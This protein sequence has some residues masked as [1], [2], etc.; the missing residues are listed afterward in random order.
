MK[1]KQV[2]PAYLSMPQRTADATWN[3]TL[4]DGNGNIKTGSGSFSGPYSFRSRFEAGDGTNPEEMLGASHAG[5]YSM[6]MSML[7]GEDG[8]EP[9]QIDTTA[10]VE[11]T[12][13]ADGFEIGEVHLQVRARVPG[14]TAEEFQGYAKAAK[15]GCPISKALSVPIKL[16][17]DLEE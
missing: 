2:E 4:K 7:L 13:T 6:A 5:C 16:D 9:E 3:G 14:I 10:T 12:K 11:L 15:D 8:H 1:H 17:A